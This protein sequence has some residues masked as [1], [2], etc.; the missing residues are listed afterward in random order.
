MLCEMDELHENP[1]RSKTT[2]A[3]SISTIEIGVIIWVYT[4]F[5]RQINMVKFKILNSFELK[6]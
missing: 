5:L 2:L 3:T 1:I 6:L 4:F